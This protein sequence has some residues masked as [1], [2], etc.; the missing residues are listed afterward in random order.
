M[1]GMQGRYLT[2]LL[3]LAVTALPK[4]DQVSWGKGQIQSAVC[5]GNIIFAVILALGI[6]YY[7]Y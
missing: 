5:Y 2:P 1:V 3:L 4:L 6:G 7:F